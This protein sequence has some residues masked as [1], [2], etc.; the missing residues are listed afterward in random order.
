MHV[1]WRREKE[2]NVI[3]HVVLSVIFFSATTF[4]DVTL[5]NRKNVT[6]GN[7]SNCCMFFAEKIMNERVLFQ[8]NIFSLNSGC[9]PHRQ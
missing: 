7:Y 1:P 3:L 8:S 4:I 6:E 2:E 9:E 5:L